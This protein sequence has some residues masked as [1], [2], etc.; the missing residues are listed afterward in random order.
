MVNN[1][2]IQW[3]LD[4]KFH[5][6]SPI[7]RNIIFKK[8]INNRKA[9]CNWIDK[10]SR[11]F[12]KNLDWWVTVP[13]S[14]NPYISDL[15]DSICILE[16]LESLLKKNYIIEIKTSSENLLEILKKTQIN[17]KK[18]L[19]IYFIKKKNKSEFLLLFKNIFFYSAIYFYIKFFSKKINLTKKNNILV[20]SYFLLNF[21]NKESFNKNILKINKKNLFLVP[22]FLPQ[23]KLNLIFRIIKKI[24]DNKHVFRENYLSFSDLVYSFFHF[25]RKKKFITKHQRFRHWDLSPIINNEIKSNKNY[26]SAILGIANYRFFK[27][28][29]K[30]NIHLSKLVSLFENQASSRGWC[31]GSRN[32][33]PKIENIGYQGYINFSQYMNSHPC[34]Y[35][36]K[37]KILPTKL[38]VISKFFIKNKREFFSKIKVILAPALN[39][40][41]NNKKIKKNNKN[42]ITLILTGIKEIDQKLISWSF[43]FVQENM[44][45]KLIIKFHPILG[46]ESFDKQLINNFKN[47]VKISKQDIGSLLDSSKIIVSTG[48]TSAIFQAL[49]KKCYLMIPVFDPWDKLN[50][51]NC[52]IPKENYVLAFNY[53]DFR[54]KLKNMIKN[55]DKKKLKIIKNNYIF[56][57]INSKNTKIFQ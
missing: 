16:T 2:K 48:P 51:V 14:R 43:K 28:L 7:V 35:E 36:Y 5:I 46:P 33:F 37:A 49:L 21:K 30:K 38:A 57:T 12:I 55:K 41:I 22:N 27:N 47:Q 11:K 20:E 39:L 10:I 31:Y 8:K 17:K 54:F 3:N 56:N 25:F 26:Y 6:S 34:S 44:S 13:S 40:K 9:F 52:K 18:N 42:I 19:K 15:F 23:K 32:V 29:K 50:L 1:R 45:I 4:D 53:Q 24:N